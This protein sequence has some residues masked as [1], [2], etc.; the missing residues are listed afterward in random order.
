MYWGPRESDKNEPSFISQ[1]AEHNITNTAIRN[2]Q[3]S[4]VDNMG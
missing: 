1:T 2:P 3:I 4:L